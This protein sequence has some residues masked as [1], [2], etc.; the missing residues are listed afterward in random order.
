MNKETPVL[1]SLE[2]I[3]SRITE[4]LTVENIARSVYFSK[5]HYCRLFREIMG[6]SVM[7]YVIK[8]KL[9]L[10]GRALLETDATILDIALKFGYDS[11]EGFTRSFKAYMGVTPTDYR[12]YNLSSIAQKTVKGKYTMLYSKCRDEI[13]RELND[14][15]AKA[16]ETAKD[17]R[18]NAVPEYEPFWNAIAD[19]TDVFADKMKDVI[20]RITSISGTPDEITNRF[21]LIIAIEDIALQSNLLAFNTGLMVS[22]GQPE[23]IRAQ[24]PLCE[25]YRDLARTSSLKAG[26]IVGLFNELSGLIFAD[27]RNTADE[28]LQAVIQKGRS[29]AESIEEDPRYSYIKREIEYLANELSSMPIENVTVVYLEDCL[30]KLNVI[31]FAAEMDIIRSPKDKELFGGLT[32]FRESLSA[33]ISF[34]QTLVMP[35]YISDSAVSECRPIKH[36]SGI[37]FQGNILLFYTRGEADKL[38]NLLG[39]EQ[40]SAFDKICGKINDFIQFTSNATEESEESAYKTIADM[41]YAIHADMTAEADKLKDHGSAVRF[42]SGEFK[43]LADS[44]MTY[45]KA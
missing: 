37:A 25:K 44:V 27:I 30:F 5:Y 20:E 45:A 32:A 15:F 38:G 16:K 9:T 11:H 18:K 43:V 34:F 1:R 33:A 17:A 36:A 28:K 12:K 8:R 4:K 22:R 42:I 29:A 13:V 31:S 40:R 35:E 10:A 14:F 26:K 41:L 7:D 39:D 21:N 19:T 6:E 23:H 2:I 3:E 24:L